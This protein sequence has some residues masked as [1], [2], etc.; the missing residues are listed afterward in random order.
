MENKELSDLLASAK[1]EIVG[2]RRRNEVLAAQMDIVE[3]FAAAL[4]LKRT[5]GGES[6]DVVWQLE[7]MMNKLEKEPPVNG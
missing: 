5:N 1:I 4:G 6:I 3:I 7:K 2:L